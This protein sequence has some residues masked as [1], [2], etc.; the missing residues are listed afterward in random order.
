MWYANAITRSGAIILTLEM[1]K[2]LFLTVALCVSAGCESGNS[3]STASSVTVSAA[4][5]LKDAFNEI[6]Q[7]YRTKTRREVTFNF[8]SSGALQKQIET[9]A[10]ADVFASAGETQMDALTEKKLI[11]P[12]SRHDF[13]SNKL[14][15][16]M[17]KDSKLELQDFPGLSSENIQKIA[18]GNPKTVPVG[19]YTE[20]IFDKLNLKEKLQSKLILGEDVRQVLDY[21]SRGETDAGVVYATDAQIAG[22]KVRVAATASAD[23]HAPIRYPIAVINDSK[24]K[25]AARDFV[26]LVLS[27]EGQKILLK[28]GFTP[29][30]KQ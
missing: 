4:V 9:G 17:P 19:Q 26:D 10:P 12:N 23:L 3:N 24:Q 28:Y 30:P 11:D 16:I 15:L 20:Q 6:G 14:V 13:T 22:D 2:I 1:K 18:V 5:S 27:D 25:K 7:L 21:V 8:G 29:I